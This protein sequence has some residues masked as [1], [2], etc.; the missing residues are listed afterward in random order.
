M[1]ETVYGLSS[2]L[3]FVWMGIIYVQL[4]LSY[5]TA[6]RLTKRGMDNG[7]ALFGWF[8]LLGL[9]ALVPGLGIYLWYRYREK[10]Q[11]TQEL[12]PTYLPKHQ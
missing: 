2:F 4:F 7:V 1:E 8:L 9:A 5:G 10:Q 11:G 3:A 6:Y 12:E